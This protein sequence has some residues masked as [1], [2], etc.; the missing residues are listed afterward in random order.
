MSGSIFEIQTFGGSRMFR[1]SCLLHLAATLQ[2]YRGAD[3]VSAALS[4]F[5]FVLGIDAPLAPFYANPQTEAFAQML[6]ISNKITR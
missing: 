4:P 3:S 6:D 2:V 1:S 5:F